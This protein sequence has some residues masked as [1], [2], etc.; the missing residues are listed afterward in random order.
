MNYLDL[1]SISRD[2]LKHSLSPSNHIVSGSIPLR[3]RLRIDGV[4]YETY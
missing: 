2:L 4:C 1:A 3:H